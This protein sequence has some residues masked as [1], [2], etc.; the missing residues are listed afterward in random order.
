MFR[1]FNR[2]IVGLIGIVAILTTVSFAQTASDKYLISAKA[3]GINY[4]EGQA[5]VLTSA[6]NSMSAIKGG[7]VRNGES[8]RTHADG[9]A[10][11]LLNPGS[12]VRIAA[13]TDV[14]FDSTDLNDVRLAINSGSAI[15]EIYATNKFTVNVETPRGTVVFDETGVYRFDVS[16]QGPATL[17]VAKGEAMVGNVKVKPN[18]SIE[19]G[20]P[21]AKAVKSDIAKRRDGLNDW[22]KSRS[23]AIAKVT[24]SLKNDALRNSLSSS[25]LANE[26]NF[27]NSYGLWIYS[28][29]FGGYCFLP[30]GV[31]WATPYGNW[32]YRSF[33]QFRWSDWVYLRM[34]APQ[35]GPGGVNCGTTPTVAANPSVGSGAVGS[36]KRDIRMSEPV[37]PPFQLIDAPIRTSGGFDAMGPISRGGRDMDMSQP[38]RG[39]APPMSSLPSSTSLP[40][41][42]PTGMPV[43]R[44]RGN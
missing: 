39:T 6:G 17:S 31:N 38:V 19:I 34:T 42:V 15:L 29:N 8:I 35:C 13:A 5:T 21:N 37:R 10:E 9:K 3:G 2:K 12:F 43:S 32:F 28:R 7:S 27:F 26:W 40:S 16:L 23:D 44:P 14:R 30:F 24:N 36:T 4:V 1:S 41:S 20:A 11:I 25:L 22:S 33:F 18:R